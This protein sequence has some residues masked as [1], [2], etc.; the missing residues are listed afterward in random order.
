MPKQEPDQTDPL[1]L[2]GVEVDDP[3][4]ESL[5]LMAECFAE[6]FLML[7]YTPGEVMELFRSREHQLAHR[8][9]AELGEVRLYALVQEL[10]APW[11]ALRER[12]SGAKSASTPESQGAFHA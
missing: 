7:G 1:E 11:Q 6:E 12:V 3:S 4:G 5:R 2:L 9:W 8:A 10:S